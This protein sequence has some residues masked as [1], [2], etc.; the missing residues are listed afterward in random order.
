MFGTKKQIF[1]YLFDQP[2][3][4]C[5]EVRPYKQKRS[6]DQ[7]AYY[8]VLLRKYAQAAG[9]EKDAAHRDMIEQ[10]SVADIYDGRPVVVS[11]RSDIPIERLP[12]YW[13]PYKTSKGFT[14]YFRL[15]GSSDMDT[16]EMSR[17]LDLLIERCHSDYPEIETMTP[18][19]LKRLKNYAPKDQKDF[20]PAKGERGRLRKGQQ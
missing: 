4:K 12:G 13:Q 2:N 14:A 5:W 11:L 3:D 8:W 10:A 16:A 1:D 7:N 6:M 18:D 17:L 20:D 15:K 19:Q 9:V